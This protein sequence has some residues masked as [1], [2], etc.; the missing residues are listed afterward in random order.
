MPADAS[1]AA[2]DPAASRAGVPA[3]LRPSVFADVPALEAGFSTRAGG[4]STGAYES[5][6][7]GFSTDDEAARVLENRRRLGAALGFPREQWVVTG[8]VH[9]DRILRAEEA[10]LFR[11][12]DGLV[13]DRAGLLLCISAADCAAVLLADP[14][15]GVLGA[16]HSGWRGTVKRI[17]EQTVGEMEALGAHPGRM[18]AYVSPCISLEHFEVG[19]EVAGQFDAS[20]V[21]RPAA[22]SGAPGPQKPH[23]DLKAA[24]A[25]Q[26][27]AA[28]VPG[29]QIEVSPHGTV[30]GSERFFSYRASEGVTGRMMGVIGRAA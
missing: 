10:G 16:C 12:Y 7:L 3:L 27:R 1:F 28:G 6:N 22:A 19:E 15:A 30:S 29:D 26:L 13:T 4:A 11:G 9:G 23:V 14:E 18:R 25:A 2:P 8:Q 24:I 5:L 17:S 20:F 21:R